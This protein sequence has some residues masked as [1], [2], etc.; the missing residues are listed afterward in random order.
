MSL[1]SLIV[2]SV[3]GC[4]IKSCIS[5]RSDEV[6]PPPPV[7]AEILLPGPA[8]GLYW[9]KDGSR[10]AL[11]AKTTSDAGFEVAELWVAD[12]SKGAVVH[13]E[14]PRH[15]IYSV[16]WSPDG[17]QLAIGTNREPGVGDP[18]EP[19][20]VLVLDGSTYA[21]TRRL[22]ASQPR[23]G[24]GFWHVDWGADGRSLWAEEF[25]IVDQK[26]TER[27]LRCWRADWE[28]IPCPVPTPSTSRYHLAVSPDGTSAVVQEWA[29]G[30]ERVVYAIR[31]FGPDGHS[32]DCPSPG[33]GLL[34][35]SA[36]GGALAF[37][38]AEEKGGAV[39]WHHPL[40]LAASP[41]ARH[42][43]YGSRRP[44][45]HDATLRLSV[46]DNRWFDFRERPSHRV[47]LTDSDTGAKKVWDWGQLERGNF[48]SRTL[49]ISPDGSRL[50]LVKG[51]RLVVWDVGDDWVN[52]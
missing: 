20:E 48:M 24:C 21:V 44:H 27:R 23:T 1:L 41:P 18:A 11:I 47:T 9:S 22:P 51:Q 17:K 40:T 45:T 43:C 13:R 2:V 39:H 12:V 42:G 50:A 31:L 5:N 35:F 29:W 37:S 46:D 34:G 32:T 10:I 52:R 19:G 26:P 49:T 15:Q 25:V 14:K 38:P 7:L 33:G 8:E 36:D 16:E 30:G 28:E 6:H 3:A 4:W